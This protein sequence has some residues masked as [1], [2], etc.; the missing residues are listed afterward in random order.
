MSCW[1]YPIGVQGM[2]LGIAVDLSAPAHFLGPYRVGVPG[3]LVT[4]GSDCASRRR[5]VSRGSAHPRSETQVR[6]GAWRRALS[7]PW[8]GLPVGE[9][10]QSRKRALGLP[11]GEAGQ[12]R[13]RAMFLL[14]QA[15]RLETGSPFLPVVRFFGWPRSCALSATSSAGPCF[16]WEQA[17]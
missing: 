13:K 16:F 1:Y 14:G 17:H 3:R 15:F 5:A 12:S 11:V 10:G 7:F 9:A 4:V 6:V 8:P 2:V